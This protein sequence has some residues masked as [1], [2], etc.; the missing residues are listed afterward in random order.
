MRGTKN[1]FG[2]AVKSTGER[3]KEAS[4]NRKGRQSR[5]HDHVA[6][7]EKTKKQSVEKVPITSAGGESLMAQEHPWWG[8]TKKW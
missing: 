8:E 3:I 7:C 4:S 2:G 5:G 1:G 6:M